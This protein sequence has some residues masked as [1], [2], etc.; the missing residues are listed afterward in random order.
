MVSD[1][2]ELSYTVGCSGATPTMTAYNGLDCSGNTGQA[3]VAGV[4]TASGQCDDMYL[5][6]S[7]DDT[8]TATS[9]TYHN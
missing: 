1:G 3:P 8:N 7:V 9:C 5:T 6:M 2:Q 4:C